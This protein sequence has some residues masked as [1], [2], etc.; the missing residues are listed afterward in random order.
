MTNQELGR[1]EKRLEGLKEELALAL[2]KAEAETR[3]RELGYTSY[4]TS[5]SELTEAEIIWL[6]Y[7]RA[8]TSASH[9]SEIPRPPKEPRPRYG[10][11]QRDTHF[12]LYFEVKEYVES[13]RKNG[14]GGDGKPKIRRG[15]K[16]EV[17]RLFFLW[18]ILDTG[19]DEGR[20]LELPEVVFKLAEEE[21][22]R[23]GGKR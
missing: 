18:R 22:R 9:T 13:S 16:E 23:H 3:I 19:G 8:I 2:R 11:E 10:K 6:R 20:L 12:K 17:D 15:D 4:V 7:Y 21:M 1:N 5:R 14:G